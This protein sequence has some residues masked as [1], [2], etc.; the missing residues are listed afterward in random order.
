MTANLAK[1]EKF[2]QG[3]FR[4][5]VLRGAGALPTTCS[6]H[7]RRRYPRIN[8][9]HLTANTTDPMNMTK[10]ANP[11]TEDTVPEIPSQSAFSRPVCFLG[12]TALRARGAGVG[13]ASLS[14]T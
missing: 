3:R 8:N 2:I 10:R 11:S 1:S 6:F 12:R 13:D 5:N 4:L 7:G 14:D 9:S